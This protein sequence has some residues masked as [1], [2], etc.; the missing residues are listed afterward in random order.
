MQI[1]L[2]LNW[3][4]GTGLVSDAGSDTFSQLEAPRGL[5]SSARRLIYATH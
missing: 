4:S 3:L 1:W 2:K 5:Q